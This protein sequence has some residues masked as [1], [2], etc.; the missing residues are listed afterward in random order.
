MQH[1]ALLLEN[2][3]RME[4]GVRRKTHAPFGER[5]RKNRILKKVYG[6]PVPT[7]RCPE[8]SQA[9]VQIT[10][11]LREALTLVDVRVLDHLVIGGTGSVS[12]SK[13]G[14]L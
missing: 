4:S 8:P 13:R 9:D 11:R 10:Q 5:N 1:M 7:L 3:H 2:D 6:V 14:L 12:L